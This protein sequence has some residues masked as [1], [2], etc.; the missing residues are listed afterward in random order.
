M[1]IL[2]LNLGLEKFRNINILHRNFI[3]KSNSHCVSSERQ[4]IKCCSL[5]ILN[6][7]SGIVKLDC[8]YRWYFKLGILLE[9]GIDHF[10]GNKVSVL[11]IIYLIIGVCLLSFIIDYGFSRAECIILQ[12]FK[13]LFTFGILGNKII[14]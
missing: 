4:Q 6:I 11:Y 13:Q 5:G 3:E 10:G 8:S 7:K 12:S 2:W 1:T 14:H 9:F